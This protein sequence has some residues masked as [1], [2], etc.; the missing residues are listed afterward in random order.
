MGKEYTE[1]HGKGLIITHSREEVMNVSG[2]AARNRKGKKRRFGSRGS[3]GGS[4]SLEEGRV[5]RKNKRYL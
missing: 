4:L 1:N 5:V 2:A 3:G